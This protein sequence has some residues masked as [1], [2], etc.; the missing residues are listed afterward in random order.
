M[1]QNNSHLHHIQNRSRVI[2]MKISFSLSILRKIYEE[3]V[4]IHYDTYNT[5]ATV[6]I[7]EILPIGMPF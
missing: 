5:D 7:H 6:D 2:D 1:D 3:T 4:D